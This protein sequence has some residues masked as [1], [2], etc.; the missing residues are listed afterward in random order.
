MKT[1]DTQ[2]EQVSD[3]PPPDP[4]SSFPHQ[5]PSRVPP[6]PSPLPFLILCIV[7]LYYRVSSTHPTLL[8]PWR[9]LENTGG[10][11]EGRQRKEVSPDWLLC[12][13][14]ARPQITA[15]SKYTNK[16]KLYLG[17]HVVFRCF[18]PDERSR[19]VS[20][21]PPSIIVCL[22]S[23]PRTDGGIRGGRTGHL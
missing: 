4:S 15:Q 8:L 11:E 21:A 7:L 3:R 22:K 5:N 6:P 18:A 2:T 12:R 10:N 1:P 16:L 19:M 23:G 20:L 14:S 9:W 13:P 17:K